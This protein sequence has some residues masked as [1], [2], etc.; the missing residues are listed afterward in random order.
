MG[1]PWLCFTAVWHCT[2]DDAV[3]LKRCRKI[4][5][6]NGVSLAFHFGGFRIVI[7]RMGNMNDARC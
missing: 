5:T 3:W 1:V 6:K 4:Q 2:D 7:C